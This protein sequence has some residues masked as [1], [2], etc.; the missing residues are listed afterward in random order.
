M[1]P[2][3]EVE[4]ELRA[5][6]DN[7]DAPVRWRFHLGARSNWRLPFAVLFGQ[8]GWFERFATTIDGTATSVRID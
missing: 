3:Y 1:V 7:E 8:R 5:P 4:M 2:V 6:G